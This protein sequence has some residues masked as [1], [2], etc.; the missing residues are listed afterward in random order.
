M[1]VLLVLLCCT[2]EVIFE[3]L[4]TKRFIIIDKQL[5]S[6]DCGVELLNLFRLL[7]DRLHAY[8]IESEQDQGCIEERQK[9]N[10]QKVQCIDYL[11][12][13]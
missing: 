12:G 8:M 7:L 4:G 13:F 11:F 6:I 5:S 2:L 10:N 1:K 3:V 9:L